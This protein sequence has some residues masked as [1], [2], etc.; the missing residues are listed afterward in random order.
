MELD[1][2]LAVCALVRVTRG[3]MNRFV[4]SFCHLRE[5]GVVVVVVFSVIYGS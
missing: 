4:E 5:K 2:L 3:G 1:R